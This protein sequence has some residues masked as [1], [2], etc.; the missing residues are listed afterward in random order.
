MSELLKTLLEKH[1]R[2]NSSILMS[3]GISILGGVLLNNFVEGIYFLIGIVA[4]LLLEVFY[5]TDTVRYNK[6][7]K[8]KLSNSTAVLIRIFAQN[9]QEYEDVKHKFASEF[10]KFLQVDNKSDFEVVYIPYNL[11]E[12]HKYND[13]DNI[14][15][16]LNKTRCIFLA[17]IRTKHEELKDETQYVTEINFGVLHAPYTEKTKKMFQEEINTISK[18]THRIEYTKNEKMTILEST[19]Y[20]LSYVC[21]YI[22]GRAYYLN[23]NVRYA[24]KIAVALFEDIIREPID[25]NIDNY[26]KPKVKELCYFIHM[27]KSINEFQKKNRNLDIVES[28]LN[29][30]NGYIVNT[31]LYNQ[32]MSVCCFLKYKDI[33]KTKHYLECCKQIK[34]NGDWKYS[35][36]FISAY[37]GESEGKV[38]YKYMQALKIPYNHSE[39]IGFIEDILIDDSREMLYFAL[40]ILYFEVEEY[41]TA[42]KVLHDYLK[43][44]N[45]KK[46]EENTIR[47]LIKRYGKNK[48]KN[49]IDVNKTK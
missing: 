34:F 30:A 41:A 18:I 20:K 43:T 14:I 23:G 8:A 28:E 32:Q 37:A 7:P 45:V 16:L 21:R 12:K 29:K 19:A 40:F 9:E 49:I 3:I 46:L 25:G 15:K 17:S 47:K 39:L 35:D 27:F 38:I 24:E 2:Q 11:T 22:V 42:R 4:I 33:K 5:I 1:Y 6:L 44:K 13:K 26:I 31:Y 48:M 10:E 36:A